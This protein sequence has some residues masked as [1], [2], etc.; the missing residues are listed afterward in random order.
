[1]GTDRSVPPSRKNRQFVRRAARKIKRTI[2]SGKKQ[3]R[4]GPVLQREAGIPRDLLRSSVEWARQPMADGNWVEAIKRWEQV[5]DRFGP[6]S[7]WSAYRGL[8]VSYT[9]RGRLDVAE[10]VAS[11]ARIVFPSSVDLAV[12]QA[13]LPMFEERWA[14]AIVR[15]QGIIDAYGPNASWKPYEGLTRC[16]EVTGK[17]TAAIETAEEG[18]RRFPD[19]PDAA[20]TWAQMA[21]VVE[22]WPTAVSRWEQV[23]E[24]FEPNVPWKAYLRLAITH[25]R[26]DD[27]ASAAATLARGNSH[28]PDKLELIAHSSELAMAERDWPAAIRHWNELL[29][30]RT[31]A[32]G[33]T[34]DG[35]S[36]PRRGN[37][38]DWY[39]EAWQT[40]VRDWATIEQELDFKPSAPLYRALGKTLANARL[41]LEG[42]SMLR[43]G[44]EAHPGDRS[45]AFDYAV[46]TLG[47]LT[48]VERSTGMRDLRD[49]LK[50]HPTLAG[51]CSDA[52]APVAG[53]TWVD[54]IRGRGDVGSIAEI[55][56]RNL[57]TLATFAPEGAE[58]TDELGSVHVI[59]LR[60]GSST[61]LELKAGRY[62]S[63]DIIERRIR[64]IS[65]RDAWDEMTA[66]VNLGYKRAREL[67]LAFGERF[68]NPPLLMPEELADAVLFFLFHEVSLHEPMR[69]LAADIAA[70][71]DDS[72]V[73]IE[74][75][76]DRYAYLDGYSFSHFDVLYLYFELRKRGVNA[77][78][79][80]YYRGKPRDRSAIT[81]VPGV[82][83]LAPRGEV[84]E[85]DQVAH[86]QALIPAGIR[87]VR[88][89]LDSVGPTLVYTSGSVIKEFAYDRSLQQGFPIEPEASVHPPLTD[90]PSFTFDLWTAA[91]LVGVPMSAADGLGTHATVEISR[92]IGDDWLAW[93]DRA[94]RAYLTAISA[95]SYAEIAARGIQEAHISDHIF[96]DSALFAGA[97][98]R[99]GGRVVLWPHS[100]NPVHVNERHI[101]SFDEV[102]AVTR[103]GYERWSE[104][105]PDVKVVHSP[106]VMLDPPTR[107]A[108][109]DPALPLSVIVIGGRSIHR[110]T[111]IL[112]RSLHEESHRAFFAGLERLQATFP[113]NLYFK[114]RGHTGEEEM[115]LSAIVGSTANWDRV[116][117]HPMRLDLP[118]MLFV[119]IS[120]GTSA[121]IEGLSR[122]IPGIVVRDFPVRDYTTLDE[123]A[124]P[125]GPVDEM[126]DVVASCTESDKYMELLERELQYYATELET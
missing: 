82:R 42:L 125:T 10:A 78:L 55:H 105:F 47:L 38:W 86:D 75:P 102:H 101:G 84:S 121:V 56:A 67:S 126:L 111:P 52:T 90:L 114:P 57:D 22:D 33:Q 44:R 49:E 40:I 12:A 118:N 46:A 18:H 92:A 64:H 120:M 35:A 25:G 2:P 21:M 115:W 9:N 73:Y 7:S 72:P 76:T 63:R 112:N 88:R 68:A 123:N 116:L 70:E 1:M 98:K 45:V 109:I 17:T 39:E 81:F 66:P 41:P 85:T 29:R 87:S 43:V 99:S 59:R 5:L 79:C 110:H 106:S 91:S 74:S 8:I 93:L 23:L 14:E 95:N 61:E 77:F 117:E 31:A 89:V 26:L 48:P 58:A 27:L 97:V 83:A 54:Q 11:R 6:A 28:N 65:E 69:R 80:R 34:P 122:G 32:E 24:R 60:H 19:L 20:M 16:Y 71:A 107:N 53:A 94:L 13:E 15:W 119:S 113:I 3:S 124:L 103:A 108:R 36:F 37:Q 30:A 51:F 62:F 4:I 100:A 104:R 50:D 96:A